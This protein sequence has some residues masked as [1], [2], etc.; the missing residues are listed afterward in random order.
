M[1]FG[2]ADQFVTDITARIVQVHHLR[3]LDV[4]VGDLAVARLDLRLDVVQLEQIVAGQHVH[5][6]DEVGEVVAHDEVGTVLLE[7]FHRCGCAL[8]GGALDRHAPA[9]SR[10]VGVLLGAGERK[11]LLDDALGQDEPGII[12]AGAHDVFELAE[13]VGAGEQRRGE[14]FSGRVEPHR[15][16]A[17]QDADAVARPDRIPVSDALDVMPHPVAVDQPRAGRLGNPDHASVDMFG[18]AGDHE[19][20]RLAQPLRPVLPDHVVIAADAAGS[21]DHRLRAQAEIADHLARGTLAALDAVGFEHR[22]TDALDRA[23]R[24]H[25]CVDAVAKPER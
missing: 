15:G 10:E 17:G 2:G 16:R 24:H 4:G 18:H 5:R 19:F 22:T 9:F 12:V 7:R 23:V 14:A 1:R 8:V 21:D 20:R 13:R 25:K 11:L 3:I 6:A